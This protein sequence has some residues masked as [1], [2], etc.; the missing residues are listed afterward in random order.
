MYLILLGAPG[1]GKGTQAVYLSKEL[2]LAHIA[3]GDLFRE[4]Q[5][6][7]TP[8]GLEAKTYMEKGELVPDDVTVRMLLERLKD[9]DCEKGAILDGF[10][11]T[12]DQAKALD[13][14]FAETDKQFDVVLHIKVT[15]EESVRR[16]SGRRICKNCQTPYHIISSPPQIADVCDKCGGQLYQRPD[17]A[18]ETVRNRLRVYMDR[19]APLID[20]YVNRNKLIEVNGEQSIEDVRKDML[21]ALK[22]RVGER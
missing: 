4:A 8:L 2:G 5:E 1:A 17:D 9:T 10:P 7:G 21:A 12:I 6:K 19:T 22:I 18:E 11:R 14:A 3:T 15:D 20:Y 16:L 13:R